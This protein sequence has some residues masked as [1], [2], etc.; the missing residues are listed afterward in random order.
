MKKPKTAT[1]SAFPAME[2]DVTAGQRFHYGMTIRDYF[3]GQVLCGI[4]TSNNFN[5]DFGRDKPR[6]AKYLAE[7]AYLIAD[8][9][10]KI[11]ETT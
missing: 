2:Y 8:E 1:E 10:L 6:M 7:N 4:F 3:A 5:I 9:M 11:R